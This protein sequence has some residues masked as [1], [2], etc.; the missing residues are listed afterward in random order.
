MGVERVAYN[1]LLVEL[2][3]R[4]PK[5]DLLNNQF[6]KQPKTFIQC[7]DRVQRVPPRMILDE[8]KLRVYYPLHA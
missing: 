2:V 1:W 7:S 4:V 5:P 3:I 8:E 6:H